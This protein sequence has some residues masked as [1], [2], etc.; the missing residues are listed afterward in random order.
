MTGAE[1]IAAERQRQKSGEGWTS[2]H[3]E[4]HAKGELVDA[5]ICYATNTDA[6]D[7][8]VRTGDT[9]YDYFAP[10]WP[11]SDSWDK[12]SKH[13]QLRSL[14]IAGALI[15]AEIDR[16]QR[17]ADASSAPDQGRGNG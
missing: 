7:G 16:L 15:A 12:R 13:D 14:T 3:D 8:F 2:A 17:V 6:H 11:W 1:M 5:A 4:Q 9:E 10:L